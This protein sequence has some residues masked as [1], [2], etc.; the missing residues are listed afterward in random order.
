VYLS[1]S[2]QPVSSNTVRQRHRFASIVPW[3][4]TKFGDRAFSVARLLL[5]LSA[6]HCIALHCISLIA[7]FPNGVSGLV[8]FIVLLFIFLFNL[9]FGNLKFLVF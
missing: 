4:R 8:M 5:V 9:L 7:Y 6:L 1:E 3:T 2:V